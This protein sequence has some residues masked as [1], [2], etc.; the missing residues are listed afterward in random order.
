VKHSSKIV[1]L[2]LASCV[3][4]ACIPEHLAK[5][6]RSE[7]SDAGTA[8]PGADIPALGQS[9]AAPDASRDV[10]RATIYALDKQ[11]YR[12]AIREDEVWDAVVTVLLRNYNLTIADR[13]TGIITTEWDSF[14]LRQAV[15]RN[16]LTVRLRRTGASVVDVTLVNNVER[17]RDA[18]VAASGVGAVWLPADDAANEVSRIVQN[19]AL[20]LNQPP[21]VMPPGMVARAIE[22]PAGSGV[23]PENR[24]VDSTVAD[25]MNPQ[26]QA[27]APNSEEFL[28][29]GMPGSY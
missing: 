27:E 7:G 2:I 29:K 26:G 3:V 10:K 5:Y 21:P 19:M 11:T 8:A 25:P 23:R 1:C 4:S 17:L 22:A 9:R 24:N 12:F 13:S 20:A 15:Y 16:R 14:Y 18:S 6:R 28:I